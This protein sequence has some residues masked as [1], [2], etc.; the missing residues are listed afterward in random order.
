MERELLYQGV[1][2]K[3]LAYRAGISYSSIGNGIERDSMPYADTALKIANVLGKPL[4][5]LLYSPS[6]KNAHNFFVSS[7][8]ETVSNNKKILEALETLSPDIREALCNFIFS[9]ANGG[10]EATY[11]TEKK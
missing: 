5:V 2:R 6:K 1:S 10:A 7:T 9:L 3:D 4:E 11:K 8:G